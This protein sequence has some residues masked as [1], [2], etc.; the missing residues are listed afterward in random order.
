MKDLAARARARKLAPAEYQGGTT[1]I[2]NLGMYGIESFAAIINPPQATILAVG[3][4]IEQPVGRNGK[5]ELAHADELH[6]FLRSPRRRWRACAQGFSPPS[7][8]IVEEPALML[9]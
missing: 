1:T 9:A 3:A 4:G 8:L 6:A 5:I 7:N 2:S